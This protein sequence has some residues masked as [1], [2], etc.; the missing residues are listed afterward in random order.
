MSV[1]LDHLKQYVHLQE[2]CSKRKVICTGKS[3]A[4]IATCISEVPV[5]PCWQLNKVIDSYEKHSSMTNADTEPTIV[6]RPLE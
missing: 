1:E 5:I 3:D 2:D 6:D 4:L